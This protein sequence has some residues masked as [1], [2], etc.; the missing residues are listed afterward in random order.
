MKIEWIY[1]EE[2]N[3]HLKTFLKQ[4]GVSRRL[5]A[6]IRHEGGQ[7]LV[8]NTSGRIV[9]QIKKGDKITISLPPEHP[10][11]EAVIPSYVPL[12]IVYEDDHYLIVNKPAR[13]TTI[14]SPLTD[15]RT[16]SLVNRIVGYYKL[17]GYEQTV[18][19]IA[20]RL[21]RDTTGLVLVAKHRYAHA[22]ID[23][24]Q[25][26]H[27]IKKEYL[28]L[29]TGKLT[30]PHFTVNLPIGRQEGSLIKRRVLA[31]GQFA[32]TQ[33]WYEKS[34]GQA[35]LYRIRLHTGRT[36]QIRVHSAYLKHP[37]LGDRLYDGA[38]VLPLQRQALHCAYLRFYHPFL[39]KDVE[40]TCELPR[41]MQQ[42]LANN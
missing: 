39:E 38:K 10:R 6:K 1:N 35:T 41:D 42:Y 15:Q 9:D 14:P 2:N 33:Y 20:T 22:L 23:Q 25:H 21:D 37:L 27:M 17:R 5:S 34:V 18:V 31:G 7:L 28:A 4:K 13:L 12:D 24:Q 11:K 36:H 30:N 8:N 16:D 29:L 19:H 40:F 32:K 3:C 26:A